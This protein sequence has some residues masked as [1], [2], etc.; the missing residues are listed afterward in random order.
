MRTRAASSA[1]AG[2]DNKTEFPTPMTPVTTDPARRWGVLF[3]LL[4]GA[5]SITA[6]VLAATPE[7]MQQLLSL[8]GLLAEPLL[9]AY[10]AWVPLPLQPLIAKAAGV[11]L[12]PWLYL[13]MLLVFVAERY[14]PADRTQR[15]F[16]VGMLQDFI[17]WFT[18]DGLM[19]ALVVG[20]IVTVMYKLYHSHLDFLTLHLMSDWPPAARIVMALLV[21]DFLN[22][23]HHYIR[24]KIDI[25]W[26]FHSVHHSQR[27]MNMFTDL[28]VHFVEHLVAKP[29]VIL[30]LLMLDLDLEPAF[31]IVLFRDWYSRIYHANLRT[32][33]GPLRHILVTPQS[34]RIH[35]SADP[36]HRDRNFG[37][38]LTVWDRI[39]GTHW[40]DYT[41]FPA[42]GITD[43][44][45][46]H[47][48]DVRGTN[49]LS[50]YLRQ[51]AYPFQAILA[52][53]RPR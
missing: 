22:W 6:V 36:R 21:V 8:A 20:T 29:I 45:F 47:E 17:A 39:F 18:L 35:H 43:P 26:L 41:E 33:F 7:L 34:H 14:I 31:W 51:L 1:A 52:R 40:P 4:V 53:G 11:F 24:H 16:S 23:F 49:I 2:A 15:V 5:F 10:Q 32:N 42:T 30:P 25:L 48:H 38:L 27:E 19:R 28:R 3:W 37:V 12:T 46:P 50:N 13:V 44:N 9:Q